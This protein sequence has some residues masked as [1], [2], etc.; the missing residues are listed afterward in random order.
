MKEENAIGLDYQ[1]CYEEARE[2]I[3]KINKEKNKLKEQNKIL[4]ETIKILCE[5]NNE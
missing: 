2:H 1:K 3:F 4:I 5:V